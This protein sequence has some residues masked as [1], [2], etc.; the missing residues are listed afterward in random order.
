M[1]YIILSCVCGLRGEGREVAVFQLWCDASLDNA[2]FNT[3]LGHD[4]L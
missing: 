3:K 1:Y 2:F 4:L